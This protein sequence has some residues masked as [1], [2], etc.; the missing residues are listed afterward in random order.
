MILEKRGALRIVLLH[1]RDTVANSFFRWPC[2]VQSGE[3][4]WMEKSMMWARTS[5]GMWSIADDDLSP[6]I[7]A[8]ALIAVRWTLEG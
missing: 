5:V 6:L 4:V 7:S 2:R 1:V 8:C 3:D